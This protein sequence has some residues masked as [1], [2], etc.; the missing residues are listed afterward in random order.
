MMYFT[1]WWCGMTQAQT[2]TKQCTA[3]NVYYS[4]GA[5]AAGQTNQGPWFDLPVNSDYSSGYQGYTVESG[6]W[7][8]YSNG[9][10]VLRARIRA[11]CASATYANVR[12]DLVLNL[13]GRT[14]T[15]TAHG[16][17]DGWHCL[18]TPTDW[19]YY[20]TV[21]SG[22]LT[23]VAGSP[24]A[25]GS[26][27][28]TGVAAGTSFQIGTG[29]S[30]NSK[31]AYGGSAWL[32][33]G[34]VVQPTSRH[35]DMWGGDVYFDFTGCTV[36]ATCSNVTAAG[37]IGTSQTVCAASFDPPLLTSVALPTGGTGTLEYIWLKSLDNGVTFTTIAGAIASTYDPGV[38]TQNTC[39]R[40]CARRSGCTAYVGESNWVCFTLNAPA[41]ATAA[42]TPA[43]ISVGSS[44]SLTATGGGT[45]RW[46][47]GATTATISVAP[48]V[49]TAYTVTV[50]KTNGCTATAATTVTVNTITPTCSNVTA[51]GSIGTSQ[52]VCATSFDPPLVTSVSLPTGGLGTLQYIW[53]KSTD[54]T[55]TFT[56]I[57]GATSATYDPGVITQSTCFRRCARR[58]NC[59]AYVGESNW[60]CF[61]LNAPATATATATPAS[62][63]TGSSS[64]L[65]ATGGG[66]Y[67]WSTGATTATISVAPAATTTYTVTVTK[68]NACTATAT[69]TVTVTAPVC[70][71]VTTAGSIGTSQTVCATSFDPPLLTSVS[72]PT[73]GVG[74][75][76]Y[77]WLKSTDNT[78][79]FTTIA[80]ATSATYDPGV[81]TQSTCFRRCARRS[82]CTAY[83]GESN[84][85]C[86][87]LNAPATVVHLLLLAAVLI[88]GVQVLQPL[89]SA[90]RLLLLL[91]IRLPLLKQ[92]VVLQRLP[93]R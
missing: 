28:I 66:T 53:L 6:T 15:G 91:L 40:R 27:Q 52:T 7:T 75:L 44:S 39:F 72:L 69:V 31:T 12:W 68:T 92:T 24:V 83:V 10:A 37:S 1:L 55:V 13:S 71:N 35:I 34:T 89:L 65:V 21:T 20:P 17:G 5:Q 84:W 79:T 14:A 38:I 49:T 32:T 33:W 25:G 4:C 51:A 93:L 26:I 11:N 36:P 74:T 82:N 3:G 45:Y 90:L 56:T 81:I 70:S 29:G 9:T 41:T 8:E 78:V 87:T 16:G 42:A 86:F 59:T 62:V 22:S 60:V 18:A 63:V 77:I 58:S 80:G 30:T 2:V 64:S 47:T 67:L 46:S 57:A 88:C 43:A 23:G 76:E 73:G 61:T 50:T 19:F 48:T 54:N 85:V